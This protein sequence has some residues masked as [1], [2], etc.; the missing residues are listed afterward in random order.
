[1]S[2]TGES[3]ASAVTSSAQKQN[4]YESLVGFILSIFLLCRAWPTS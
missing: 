2:I 3:S 4:T 1:M